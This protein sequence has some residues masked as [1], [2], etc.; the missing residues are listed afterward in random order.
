MPWEIF[1]SLGGSRF[2][3]LFCCCCLEIEPR[4]ASNLSPSNLI[5]LIAGITATSHH[6]GLPGSLFLKIGYFQHLCVILF[7]VSESLKIFVSSHVPT[8]PITTFLSLP[9]STLPLLHTYTSALP[10]SLWFVSPHISACLVPCLLCWVL[11]MYPV[12][13]L[14][15]CWKGLC[16][17]VMLHI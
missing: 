17:L 15:A 11:Q 2:L 12:L 6:A 14:P 10:G 4:L 9:E 1:P 5:L 16:Q 8:E 13:S 7:L 3:F